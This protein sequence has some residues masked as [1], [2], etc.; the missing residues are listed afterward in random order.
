MDQIYVKDLK[1]AYRILRKEKN[2]YE[3]GD[4]KRVELGRKMKELKAKIEKETGGKVE[5]PKIQDLIAK[6]EELNKKSGQAPMVNLAKFSFEDL[7]FH[8]LKRTEQVKNKEEY[9]KLK[10][11]KEPESATPQAQPQKITE[12]AA[13]SPMEVVARSIRRKSTY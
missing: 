6:I 7:E 2:Q 8:Y 5:D 12:D 3:P 10:G 13:H 9:R 11:I 4:E 1:K